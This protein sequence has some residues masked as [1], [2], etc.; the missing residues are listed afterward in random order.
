MRAHADSHSRP[1]PTH[2]LP[3]L[4]TVQGFLTKDRFLRVLST[5]HILPSDEEEK[6]LLLKGFTTPRGLD[7]KAMLVA[8]NMI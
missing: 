4:S 1:H 6:A 8:L 3:P 2:P 7:Y 5:L